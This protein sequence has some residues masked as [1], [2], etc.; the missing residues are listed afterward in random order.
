MKNCRVTHLAIACVLTGS[1]AKE[2]TP[3]LHFSY[4]GTPVQAQLVS[5]AH[6]GHY[7]DFDDGRTEVYHVSTFVI[8]SP[9]SF[10]GAKLEIEHS[11]LP[12]HLDEWP[13]IGFIFRLR[14]QDEH[15]KYLSLPDDPSGSSYFI[16]PNV[17]IVS[18]IG[19]GAAN[20]MCI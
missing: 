4:S 15:A 9:R 17:P 8:L 6:D 1:C 3:E 10:C 13:K 2:P 5:F 11:S 19:K 16:Y 14:I 7:Y 20:E 12:D 18:E